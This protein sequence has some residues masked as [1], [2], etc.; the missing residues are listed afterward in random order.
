[1][2][3]LLDALGIH[4]R[5][6]RRSAA[7]AIWI[8]FTLSTIGLAVGQAAL[9]VLLSV[10]PAGTVVIMIVTWSLWTAWHSVAFV[11]HRRTLLASAP[12]PYRSAFLVHLVPGLSVSFSQM[13]RPAINGENLRAGALSV[14]PLS[15]GVNLGQFTVAAL[16]C[17]GAL[18]L[19]LGAWRTLGT[20]R[21]GFVPEFVRTHAFVPTRNG[22]YGRVRHPLF[23]SGVIGSCGLAI[24]S[25][26]PV[27]AAAAVVNVGYGLVYNVLEDRRLNIVFGDRYAGYARSLPRILPIPRRGA[28]QSRWE[29]D[30]RDR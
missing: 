15:L 24:G 26:T 4:G 1:M 11:R 17:V 2:G 10:G 7:A 6:A 19:F 3:E 16:V 28:A 8:G 5:L 25:G 13:L 21:V 18:V 29:V 20:A 27:A 14:S 30:S 23:W 9:E 12:L 22:L